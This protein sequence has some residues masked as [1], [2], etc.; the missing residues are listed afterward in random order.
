MMQTLFTPNVVHVQNEN[1]QL[2][3]I[4]A[5]ALRTEEAAKSPLI[6][7]HAQG[8]GAMAFWMHFY[9]WYQQLEVVKWFPSPAFVQASEKAAGMAKAQAASRGFEQKLGQTKA[10]TV[11]FHLLSLGVSSAAFPLQPPGKSWQHRDNIS[12][13]ICSCQVIDEVRKTNT[14]RERG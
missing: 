14:L 8:K 3:L 12:P 4:S 2:Q 5:P 6:T 11:A 13:Q 10:A 9:Q 7:V 1:Q